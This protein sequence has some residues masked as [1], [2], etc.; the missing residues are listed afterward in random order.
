MPMPWG[1]IYGHS[2]IYHRHLLSQLP[3]RFKQALDVG[4]GARARTVHAVDRSSEMIAYAAASTPPP[5]NITWI[6]GD[7][8]TLDLRPHAYDVVTAIA[9][10]HHMPLDRGLARLAELTRPGGVLVVL[11]LY[12]P[13]TTTDYALNAIAAVADPIAHAMGRRTPPPIRA[14]FQPFTTTLADITAIAAR[15]LER[16]QIRRHVFYRYSLT[17]QRPADRRFSTIIER[18]GP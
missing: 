5:D 1:P 17:W 9:S 6:N 13:A 8:L 7:V 12:R 18:P 16:A 11:G 15:H 3:P 10:L 2:A 4:C 14:P